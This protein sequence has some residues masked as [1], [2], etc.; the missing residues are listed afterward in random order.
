M[1]NHRNTPG[2]WASLIA[3]VIFIPLLY[4][5]GMIA[6]K[7]RIKVAKVGEEYFTRGDLSD[8]IRDMPAEERPNIR[9]KG[10]L[11]V[12]LSEI[13]DEHIKQGQAAALKDQGK[14][15][16]TR[17]E[18]ELQYVMRYPEKFQEFRQMQSVL[19]EDQ[20][21]VYEEE[22]ELGID[23]EEERLYG[24]R[25][26][27]FLINDAMQNNTLVVSDEQYE[28]QY[29]LRKG[30]M[31]TFEQVAI[32]GVYLPIDT[33]KDVYEEA[34]IVRQKLLDG[35]DPKTIA[36]S[37]NRDQAGYLEVGLVNQGSDPKFTMFW[38]QASQSEE[39]DIF[40]SYIPGWQRNITVA[41]EKQTVPIPNSQ[42]VSRVVQ[43]IPAR[44]KTLEEAKPELRSSILFAEIMERLRKQA[45][46]EFYDDKLPD[47]G[48][49]DSAAPASIMEQQ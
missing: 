28:E 32:K 38:Q 36:E 19:A 47:P 25:A 42:L 48:M 18:A 13:I 5:C 34:E 33:H 26:L 4:S 12:A 14:I 41:G 21:K 1:S 45:G 31:Y 29:E 43:Y 17:Q 9:T 22:R 16:V 46:V 40:S 2:Y 20:M 23:R 15:A 7:D 3:V 37:Y 10:D 39:G 49:Y 30:Q 11:R 6:D 27:M 8:A 24:D 35:A 44:Q